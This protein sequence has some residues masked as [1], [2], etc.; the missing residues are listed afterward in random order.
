MAEGDEAELSLSNGS[1][2]YR[3][4]IVTLALRIG[5]LPAT[6]LHSRL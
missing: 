2:G 6:R 5:K 4:S 3:I 1:T